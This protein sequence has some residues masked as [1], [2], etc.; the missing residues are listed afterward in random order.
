MLSNL[1]KRTLSNKNFTESIAK[2]RI[3]H[4]SVIKFNGIFFDKLVAS[5]SF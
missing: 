4:Y 2:I 1:V 5:L 3:N